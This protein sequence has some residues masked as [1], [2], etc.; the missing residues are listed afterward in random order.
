MYISKTFRFHLFLGIGPFENY[1]KHIVSTTPLKPIKTMNQLKQWTEFY[2]EFLIPYFS[3]NFASFEL[4]VKDKYVDVHISRKFC[5]D[6][7]LVVTPKLFY[8]NPVIYCAILHVSSS[9][10]GGCGMWALSLFFTIVWEFMQ[11]FFSTCKLSWRL[12]V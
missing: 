11:L 5:S 6:D 3:A 2:K 7:F 4:V 8:V 1:S 9:L 12:I 10:V